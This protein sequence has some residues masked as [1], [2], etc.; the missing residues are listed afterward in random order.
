MVRM[1]EDTSTRWKDKGWAFLPTEHYYPNPYE[2]SYTKIPRAS[3]EGWFPDPH[4]VTDA[5]ERHDLPAMAAWDWWRGCVDPR[6][7]SGPSP[8]GLSTALPSAEPFTMT[9]FPPYSQ[10]RNGI[11]VFYLC[12]RIE[13]LVPGAF[14]GCYDNPSRPRLTLKNAR[15]YQLSGYQTDNCT[16]TSRIMPLTTDIAAVKAKIDALNPRGEGTYSKLGMVWGHR[17][18]ASTWRTTWNNATHPV[19]KAAGVQKVIVLLTD[20][21]DNHLDSEVAAQH[22]DDACTAAKND[23]IKVFVIAAMHPDKVG[24]L[25][26]P[27][28]NCSSQA[29]DSDGTYIIIN[30]ATPDELRGAF[31][32]VGRQLVR[33][34][35]VY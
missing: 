27:L 35:R 19:D 34:R 1:D 16:L 25:E 31:R 15:A 28:T 11:P 2:G 8:P 33:F 21:E 10:D 4:L 30:N 18:L 12:R 13:P 3:K 29:D 22:L 32:E 14:N 23:G 9:F 20:G 6:R 7:M 17:L 24:D 5:S 26:T